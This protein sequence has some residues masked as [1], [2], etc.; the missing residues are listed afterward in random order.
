MQW[1]DYKLISFARF[2]HPAMC[3]IQRLQCPTE[4]EETTTWEGKRRLNEDKEEEEYAIKR[5]RINQRA[6][7]KHKATE[8]THKKRN[9]YS[10]ST[11]KRFDSAKYPSIF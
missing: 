5:N 2:G 9:G 6:T 11:R 8:S 3:H 7:F 10:K 4:R 1:R